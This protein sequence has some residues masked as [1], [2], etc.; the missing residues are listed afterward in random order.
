[1]RR[2]RLLLVAPLVALL[3]AC[4][5]EPTALKLREGTPVIL[6]SIDTL[7]SDHLPIY[8]YDGVKTPAIDALRKEG[9]LFQHA[10]TPTPL[11]LPAHTSLLTGTLPE[12]HGVRDNVGY[13]LDKARRKRGEPPLLAPMLK[14]RGYA[15]AAAVS[16]YVLQ[17]TTGIEEGFDLYEDGIEFQ[18]G[19]G[20]GQLQRPGGESLS[21]L[22]PW[23]RE[24]A[25]G[26]FFVWLH[27][28]EPHTPYEPPPAFAA[29]GKTPYDGEIAAA[30]A[31]V[32]Q[33][34]EQ[35]RE[36]ERWDDALV[37]LVADHGEGLGDHGED[38]H[39]VLLYREAIQVPMV[40]KL[41]KGELSGRTAEAP[42]SLVDVAP[43]VA[44]LLGIPR[45]AAW[46]RPSLL[47]AL[48]VG[49]TPAKK[50]PPAAY[51]ETFYARLHFGWSDLAAAVDG[52]H[53]LVMG[54][55]P[56]LY[57]LA[58][59]P[60]EKRNL[61][62]NERRAFGVLRQEIERH[63]RRLAPPAE[64]DEESRKAMEALGYAGSAASPAEGQ[65]PD[66]R[67]HLA[68][69]H[70][71][72]DGFALMSRKDPAA[73]VIAFRRV[74]EANPGMVDAWEFLG[75]AYERMDRVDDALAAYQEALK[76]SGGSPHIAMSAASLLLQEGRLADAEEHAKLALAAHP[77]FAHGLL[78]QV[79]LARHDLPAAEREARRATEGKGSAD[80]VGPPLTLAQVLH[81]QGRFE[82]ALATTDAALKAWNARE[83]KDP[84][85]VRGAYALRGRIFAD[86]GRADE[87]EKAF[88]QE[89]AL[90]PDDPPA[91][92]NLALLYALTGR[93]AEVPDV[94]RELVEN[95]SS[96]RA[97][98]EAAQ[99][100]RV[101]ELGPQAEQLL[102][103]GRRL[104]PSSPLLRSAAG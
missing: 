62:P 69:L 23:L 72:K 7:R 44:D 37:V 100:L 28:Y 59:D 29:A 60:G 89:I 94:L 54:P 50:S 39:G 85:L 52:K 87:A 24:H 40:V 80:R 88:R 56:E 9:V 67:E 10:Y 91:Y 14:E 26:P 13:S 99:T 15:T 42:V 93:G 73:A 31:V 49:K 92:T 11:T 79:A 96:P 98:K 53:H 61:M 95:H 66:P 48:D 6:V 74:V 57:D 65:L 5:G 34:V 63:D 55:H 77:S 84:D 33:L 101:L 104:Y 90:F 41:P 35:L 8:G 46:T 1:V 76:R 75:R 2:A 12:V 103:R 78:A 30:D 20:L 81:A 51:A 47:A 83:A 22:L 16:A 68:E 97:Y 58:A 18:S 27:L 82:E 71:L 21:R 4:H 45:P 19:R 70:D 32:G 17:G 38:E 36:L 64:V 3:A 43:T 102:A 86:L 25:K